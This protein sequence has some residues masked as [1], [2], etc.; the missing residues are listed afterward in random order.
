MPQC[1]FY[2][3]PNPI[4]SFEDGT[5]DLLD[6]L[7]TNVVG[8]GLKLDNSTINV[9]IGDGLLLENGKITLD[10]S[11]IEEYLSY[12]TNTRISTDHPFTITAPTRSREINT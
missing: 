3:I 10:H 12:N 1:I 5:A 8:N 2:R 4:K 7:S 9:E 11:Y 6:D